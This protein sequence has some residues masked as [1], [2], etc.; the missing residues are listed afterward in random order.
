[1]ARTAA[2]VRRPEQE[3]GPHGREILSQRSYTCW[4]AARGW[5]GVIHADETLARWHCNHDYRDQRTHDLFSDR[6]VF[7]YADGGAR[8]GHDWKPFARRAPAIRF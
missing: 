2:R 4:G 5:C 1:M 7:C 3:F 8:T 6:E